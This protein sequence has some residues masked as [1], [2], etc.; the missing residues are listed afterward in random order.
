MDPGSVGGQQSLHTFIKAVPRARTI[1]ARMHVAQYYTRVC[2]MRE[3]SVA[4]M[5]HDLNLNQVG[6]Y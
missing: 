2:N 1:N 3:E 5:F 4:K 6:A